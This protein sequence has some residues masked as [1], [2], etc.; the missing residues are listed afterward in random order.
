LQTL[1][2]LLNSGNAREVYDA[3]SSYSKA[4]VQTTT[5]QI[6]SIPTTLA[7]GQPWLCQAT[8]EALTHVSDDFTVFIAQA[9]QFSFSTTSRC[10]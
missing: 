3:A 9:V 10:F 8:E 6:P 7:L 4:E 1:F 2:L 5:R